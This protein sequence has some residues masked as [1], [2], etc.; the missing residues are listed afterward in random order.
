MSKKHSLF[1][2]VRAFEAEVGDVE[3]MFV[4]VWPE[5]RHVGAPQFRPSGGDNRIGLHENRTPTDVLGAGISGRDHFG[6]LHP[7]LG[8]NAWHC[9]RVPHQIADKPSWQRKTHPASLRSV[10]A[11]K[12]DESHAMVRRVTLKREECILWAS[13]S[14][15]CSFSLQRSPMRRPKG[16]RMATREAATACYCRT[17]TCEPGPSISRSSSRSRDAMIRLD[18]GT[19]STIS[20]NSSTA[21]IAMPSLKRIDLG[22]AGGA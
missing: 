7:T 4:E 6:Q 12:S 17:S 5:V 3:S 20:A 19:A 2:A 9:F 15:A 16:E 18:P 8:G 1:A 11:R 14:L 22:P 13:G 10:D 21:S